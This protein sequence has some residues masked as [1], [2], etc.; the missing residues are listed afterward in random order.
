MNPALDVSRLSPPAQKILG[1]EAPAALKGMAAKGIVPGVRPAEVVAVV[2]AL[3]ESSDPKIAEA[4]SGTLKNLPPPLLAGAL[5]ADLEPGVVDLLVRLYLERDEVVEKLLGMPRIAVESVVLVASRGSERSTEMV[6]TNEAKLLEHPEI[7]EKL[8]MNEAT[9]MSTADRILELAVRNNIELKIP[10][11]REAAAAIKDE[12]IAEASE[13]LT[14]DDVAFK[15]TAVVAAEV[16]VDPERE[17]THE[18][19]DEGEE[20]LAAKVLPLNVVLAGLS[21]SGK[22]RRAQL[23]SSAERMILVRDT[24]RLVAVAAIRSPQIQEPEVARITMSRQVSDDVLREI[25]K[26]TEWTKNHQIKV[27]LVMNPRTPFAITSKF[28]MH[29][30]EHE[31]KMLAKNKNVPGAVQTAA[32]NQLSRKGKPGG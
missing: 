25:A 11:Y 9:R 28:V 12:L 17:D 3:S 14:Y 32:R 2:A 4:A 18:R 26:N 10:A 21:I 30:R 1:P 20:V 5:A 13:E 16:V 7:I 19:N 23:G 15:E 27:N 31:L 8:Y 29:M 24:N 6:A 22:I